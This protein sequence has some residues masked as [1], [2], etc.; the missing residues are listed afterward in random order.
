MDKITK[1]VMSD[2]ERSPNNRD[3]Y[4]QCKE[5]IK[6]DKD[7][8]S[9]EKDKQSKDSREEKNI[10]EKLILDKYQ[11]ETKEEKDKEKK[12]L[13]EGYGGA[14][15]KRSRQKQKQW[16]DA[17]LTRTPPVKQAFVHPGGEIQPS[18]EPSIAIRGPNIIGS[19]PSYKRFDSPKPPPALKVSTGRYNLYK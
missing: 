8:P 4:D 18:S 15:R 5:E 7:P 13:E 11:T 6:S 19:P 3:E 9:K 14:R 16:R 2:K 1:L 17:S 12:L 10:V